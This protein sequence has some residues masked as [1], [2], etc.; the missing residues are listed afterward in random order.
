MQ[1][2][3]NTNLTGTF[4]TLKAFL[5]GIVER[6]RGAIVTMASLGS[7]GGVT[8]RGELCSQ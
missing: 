8:I 3:I 5:P 4:L 7:P 1:R 2:V 6:R